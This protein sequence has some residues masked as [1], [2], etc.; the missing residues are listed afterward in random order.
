[1]LWIKYSQGS[2][3]ELN[4]KTYNQGTVTKTVWHWYKDKQ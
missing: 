2:L 1:M 3:E 4:I